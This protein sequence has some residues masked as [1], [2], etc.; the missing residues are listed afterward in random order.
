M[1]GPLAILRELWTKELNTTEVKST[2]QYV[3][4]LREKLEETLK[5]ARK[6]DEEG[7]ETPSEVLQSQG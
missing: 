3:F 2:Y 7:K 4:D 6:R 5:L 1:R